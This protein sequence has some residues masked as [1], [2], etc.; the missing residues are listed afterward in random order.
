MP[1]AF[2]RVRNC[3]QFYE[4]AA[5]SSREYLW[6]MLVC[7]GFAE[8]DFTIPEQNVNS[9]SFRIVDPMTRTAAALRQIRLKSSAPTFSG[10]GFVRQETCVKAGR[11]IVRPGISLVR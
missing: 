4:C 5:G 1:L 11:L 6:L 3:L 10:T 7:L 2:D 8:L 9:P